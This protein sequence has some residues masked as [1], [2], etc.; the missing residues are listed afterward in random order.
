[1]PQTG[2]GATLRQGA[3]RGAQAL[4]RSKGGEPTQMQYVSATSIEQAVGLLAAE[5]GAAHV[6]AGGTDLVVQMS[7]GLRAPELVVDIKA[8][9]EVV[10]ITEDAEGFH[11]GAAVCGAQINEHAGLRKAW[12]GVLEAIDLIGSMQVQSRATPAGNLC[13]ASPAADSVPAMIAAGAS[14]SVVGP[15]GRRE[16]PVEEIPTGPGKTSLEKGEVIVAINLPPRPERAGDA[17]LRFIPRTEMD[18][19]VVGVGVNLVLDADGTCSFA[20]VAIGAVAPTALLVPA[21]SEALVGTT[22]DDAA[23]ERAAEAVRGV[24][25]PIDDKRGTAEYRI[26][27]AGVIFKRTVAAAL[28]RAQT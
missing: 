1:M 22:L 7:A 26:R 15:K 14:A 3:D 25:R 19:A 17:Y 18:I 9:P 4:A 10:S 11:I 20:R 2:A 13:N 24:C 28:A 16:V 8:I 27:I 21:A 23:L 6:L 12:P 5:Q